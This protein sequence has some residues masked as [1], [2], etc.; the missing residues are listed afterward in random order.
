MRISRRSKKPEAPKIAYKFNEGIISPKVLVLNS[1][2][3]NLGVMTA[4]EAIRKAREQE[5]D[6][7]EIN[8]KTDPPVVKIM[9]YGQFRYQKE[10]EMRIKKAH[11]HVVDIKGIRMSLR[12]GKHDFDIRK[13]QALKFLNDGDKVRIELSLRGRENQQAALGIDVVKNFVKEI[14]AEVATRTEQ[15]IEKQGPKITTIIAKS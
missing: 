13:T 15:E 1:D 11:Q 7:V 9:D 5:L 8:P 10:K 14:N 6:V 4:G 2:G 3:S 12:I